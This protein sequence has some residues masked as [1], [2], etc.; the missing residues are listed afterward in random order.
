M[1]YNLMYNYS[2]CSGDD[3]LVRGSNVSHE[4]M[5]ASSSQSGVCRVKVVV[6]G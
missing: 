6:S 3:D 2:R 5:G 1:L 4:E